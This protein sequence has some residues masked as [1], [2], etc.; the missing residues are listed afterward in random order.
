MITTRL[1]GFIVL[2]CLLLLVAGG[3]PYVVGAS[4]G[5]ALA[6]KIRCPSAPTPGRVPQPRPPCKEEEQR[7]AP[8]AAVCVSLQALPSTVSGPK[9][10]AQYRL[11]ATNSGRGDAS[12]LYIT[13]PIIATQQ[14]LLEARFSHTEGW[15]SEQRPDSVTLSMGTVRRSQTYTATL[16]VELLAPIAGGGSMATRATFSWDDGS[17]GGQG[18]TNKVLLNADGTR[19]ITPSLSIE[20]GTASILLVSGD[21]FA[22]NERVSIWLHEL[23]GQDRALPEA[24]SDAQGQLMLRV[25]REASPAGNF[26]VAQGAC[27]Q[28]AFVSQPLNR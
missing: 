6:L 24:W 3:A 13:V 26:L 19:N 14:R 9:H 27:S 22:S 18:T 5:A 15:V 7:H 8:G 1:N 4:E 10:I 20:A 23:T 17:D 16:Q 21:S 28:T 12:G 11:V 25:K 2:L